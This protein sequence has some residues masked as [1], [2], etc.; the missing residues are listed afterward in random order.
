MGLAGLLP[1]AV[2]A[3]GSFAAPD[4]WQGFAERALIAYGAVILGFLGAVHWGLA[5][6]TC[7]LIASAPFDIAI[8]SVIWNPP[9]SAALIK[10]GTAM[11][12]MLT[13]TSPIWQVAVAAALAQTPR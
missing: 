7:L 11:A 9:V 8:S 13:A 6:G 3:L 2:S 4:S 5:L 1:F 10:M 12:L